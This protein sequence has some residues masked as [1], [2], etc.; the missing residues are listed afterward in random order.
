L[1]QS[2]TIPVDGC[3]QDAVQMPPARMLGGRVAPALD[4][5]VTE[6]MISPVP[7][8]EVQPIEPQALLSIDLT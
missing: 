2:S 8:S 7:H 6:A 4:R 1:E 3:G 5:Q